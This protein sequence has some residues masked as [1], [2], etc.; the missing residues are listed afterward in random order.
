MSNYADNQLLLAV[1]RKQQ[2]K[3]AGPAS[4]DYSMCGP[5]NWDRSQWEAFRNQ[6][7][8]Y[9]FGLDGTGGFVSPPTYD[10]APP[11]VFELMGMREPP[12]R[13]TRPGS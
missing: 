3:S 10:N 2:E 8:H 13:M 1:H 11:W 7:G 6:Y 9:P 4:S 5:P 12:I